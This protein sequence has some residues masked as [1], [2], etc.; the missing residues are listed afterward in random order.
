MSDATSDAPTLER[1]A[2]DDVAVDDGWKLIERFSELVRE[3]GSEA[4][5][6]GANHIASE[7]SRLG[8]P[9]EVLEPDLYLSLPRAAAVEIGGHRFT[10]KPPAFSGSTPPDGLEGELV[11]VPAEPVEG[12]LGDLF[13]DRYGDA[14]PDVEGRIVVTEGLG[15]PVSV[16][17][18]ERAGARAQVYINPGESVHWGICTPVWGAPTDRDLDRIPSTPVVSVNGSDGDEIVHKIGAGTTAGRV[19]AALEEGWYSCPLPVATIDGDSEDFLLV[20]GHYDSWDVGVGDNAVGD[21]TLLELARIFH[22]RRDRL[23]RSLRIAWWPGHS[24]G[25][26]GGS[27]WYADR[28]ASELARRCV[29][30]INIDS[31][32]CWKAT[33]YDSVAWMAECEDFCRAAI[34]DATGQKAE[35]RRPPRA[36]DYSFGQLGLTSFFMLLSEIP[37]EERRRLDFYPVGGCGGNIAWHTENDRLDI[38]DRENLER[39]LRVYVTAVSRVLNGEVLP[40]DYRRTL[41]ELDRA[42]ADYEEKA[43]P[44][45][46]LSGVRG[47][48]EALAG[49]LEWLYVALEGGRLEGRSGAVNET[50]KRIARRLVP[51]SYGEEGRFRHDPALP[52]PPFAALS[53]VD[54][55]EEVRRSDPERLPFLQVRIARRANH[56]ANELWEAAETVRRLRSEGAA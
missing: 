23:R 39:D 33:A 5:W 26:Y 45:V 28:F 6:E 16:R 12:E 22:G 37:E 11:Y 8:V 34:R 13:G 44:D 30:T 7:L 15:L 54:D 14:L 47:E 42:L 19:F 40:F 29:A 51:L 1:L 52:R 35:G 24:T 43:R 32:G 2:L 56:V 21:A 9:H 50:L 4:E 48:L 53:V 25:R 55:L 41:D 38:A 49:E 27:T 17:R 36:G 31:P 3:S 20:H 46:D 18:F 10:A